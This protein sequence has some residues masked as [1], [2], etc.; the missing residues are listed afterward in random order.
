MANELTHKQFFNSPAVKQKFAEVVNGNGQQFVASLLSVVQNNG[1]LAKASNESIMT[2]AMKAAVLN[3]P[4]E[5]SLGYAYIVP[6]KNQA[7]FQIGYKGLIQLAQRSGQV[8][9][10]NAGEI[11]E[12]QYKGFNPLTE[13]L[14]VDMSAIPKEKEKVVGYFAFMRLANGFEKTVFWT[15]ERVQTHG[16]KYSQS[17]SSKYSP[18]QSDFDAMARKTVLKHM[19]STYAPLSTELQ[20]AIVADNEDSTVSNKKEMK[21]VTQDPAAETLDGILGAPDNP[22]EGDNVVDGEITA[23]TKT[24]P[25]TAKKTANPDELASTEYPADEIPDFDEETGEVLEEF[26]FFEGN[27][28]NIKE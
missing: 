1:L 14:E 28:T 21:D 8:T 10:L 24:H 23:E 26:S 13:D 4:I 22:V 16:K 3:L 12:S 15:K 20:E 17:F 27:T 7:Q 19:L 5:P 11:Y 2:S 25:K 9:R 6:Y 18:W